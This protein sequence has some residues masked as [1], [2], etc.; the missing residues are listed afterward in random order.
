V[1]LCFPCAC[2]TV[3][4]VLATCAALS[5]AGQ[6][7]FAADQP[8]TG[9]L[10][11]WSSVEG[12]EGLDVAFEHLQ[13]LD[14]AKIQPGLTAI[15]GEDV[16]ARAST[17]ATKPVEGARFEV[18]AKYIDV[19]YVVKGQEMMG[20]L[21]R[22]DGLTAVA[23][24]DTTKDVGL[25]VP[26]EQFAKV[27]V[28]AGQYAVFFPGQPHLPG[29]DLEGAHDVVKVVVKVSKVWYDAHLAEKRQKVRPA[30]EASDRRTKR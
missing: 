14:P 1:I 25:F 8:F 10:A 2:W 22:A 30:V 7:A 16:F 26:P 4:R 9:S 19:Q 5:I 27:E 23:P 28:R 13:S 3:S 11:A 18:H 12:L 20:F 6:A 29:R 15:V 21:P 24:F 17:G